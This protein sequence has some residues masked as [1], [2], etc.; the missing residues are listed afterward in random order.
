MLKIESRYVTRVH[1]DL[2][3]QILHL[4]QYPTLRNKD[5]YQDEY[6]TNI[7]KKAILLQFEWSER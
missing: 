7:H 2:K 5:N 1:L 3:F 6:L 4:Y